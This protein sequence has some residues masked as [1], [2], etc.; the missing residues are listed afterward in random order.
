MGILDRLFGSDDPLEDELDDNLDDPDEEET[1]SQMRKMYDRN[2]SEWPPFNVLYGKD[3]WP[4]QMEPESSE[5]LSG[6]ELY[7]VDDGG[8]KWMG[9]DIRDMIENRRYKPEAPTRIGYTKDN[10]KGV[11]DV[12]IDHNALF[13]HLALFGQTGYGKSTL[14]RNIML[15]WINA[16]FG[17]CYID[18]KG[19]DS[20]ELL[21]QLPPHR[22]DDVVWVEPNNSSRA[23]QV[24]FNVFDTSAEPGDPDYENE[25]SSVSSD[26]VQILKD[27]SDNWGPQIGNITETMVTQLIRARDP[28]NPIDMVK[29]ITDEEERRVFAD[30]YGDDLEKVFMKRIAEQD[31]AA[32]DPILRRVRSWVES[33]PTRQIMAHEQ[34]QIN[35][36][37]AVQ[38][39]KLLI[40]NTSN[41]ESSTTEEIVTRMV[42]SRV[43]STIRTR[44][45]ESD[46]P[47]DPYFL[48][49][50]EFDKV[51]SDS[52]DINDIVSQA[53][54]FR[55]SVFVANQQPSQ[56]P[57]DVKQAMQQVQSLLSF[58]PGQN[59]RDQQEIA[60][61]LGDV[62]SWKLSDLDRFQVVGRPYM[63]ESQQ[64]AMV[65]HTFGEYPPLRDKEEVSKI[66]DRSLDR[67]GTE[68]NIETD[69]DEYG[70]KR[71]A[72]DK[73]SGYE[74]NRSGDTITKQQVLECVY[75]ASLRNS[76]KE[77]DDK[78]DWVKLGQLKEQVDKYA[79]GISGA[80]DSKLSN[81]LEGFTSRELE[82]TVSGGNAYFRLG[83]EGLKKAFEPDTGA[84][85][86]G[87]KSPHRIL[88]REGHKSFTKLG[89][90]VTLPSQ[91]QAG[92]LPDGVAKP[93]INPM[94]ESEDFEEAVEK[95]K[96]LVRKYPR[97]AQLFGD[98]EVAL[99]AESTTITRPAQTIKNLIKAVQGDEHC[100]FIVKDGS[101]KRDEFEYWARVGQE[102]MTD[103]PFVRDIDNQGNR[104]FY[105]TNAKIKLSNKGTALV[106][107]DVGQASWME[108]GREH[109]DPSSTSDPSVKLTST[110]SNEPLATFDFPGELWAK[111]SPSEFPYHYI[112]DSKSKE[113]LV[114]DSNGD[115][116]DTYENLTELQRDGKYKTVHMPIIPEQ[117]FPGG[118]YPD[119]D[120]WSFVIIPESNEKGPQLYDNGKIEPLLPEDG[121]VID[122]NDFDDLKIDI[123]IESELPQDQIKNEIDEIVNTDTEMSDIEEGIKSGPDVNER[124]VSDDISA[125]D[126]LD[127]LEEDEE[128]DE[129]EEGTD[130]TSVPESHDFPD[131][132][133]SEEESE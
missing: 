77:I 106:P 74:I 78:D 103:P 80:H 121:A 40:I 14:M 120:Q 63:N 5:M 23:K 129:E 38:D 56:L 34:S 131:K 18:P 117:E 32:F 97:L 110:N 61:V 105:T 91:D 26:F 59:P 65:I 29:I 25:V 15:Q 133:T 95:E 92:A 109:K 42:I 119:E 22:I 127:D 20:Y 67:Y 111:P 54:S 82:K 102:I 115:V 98:D 107:K 31:Q 122:P 128:E 8:N 113:T 64:S 50:D 39:G 68:P 90:D 60:Q 71:F 79:E 21:E 52:F 75:T 76:N 93:P 83:N 124:D 12:Y 87:G 88:L 37:E 85:A 104:T 89:Y 41:I 99:E 123:D 69:L 81:I 46:D 1:Q 58:H 84:S 66:I 96:E 7:T 19:D 9:K 108:F 51:I 47:L 11:Q 94:E 2:S 100:V 17:V 16:G 70:A 114:K 125:K 44:D 3:K 45:T 36:S 55:L 72:E 132:P 118:E 6:R 43:W 27:K 86:S 101:D 130:L 49:I 10:V 57:D 24:G 30:K 126:P 112:R 28:F 35:I 33:R 13:R 62:D 53:R 116:V 4:Y 73:S 48:C